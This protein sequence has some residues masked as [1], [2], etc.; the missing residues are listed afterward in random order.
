[1][2]PFSASG[3]ALLRGRRQ[4]SRFKEVCPVLLSP[5]PTA[6]LPLLVITA[7]IW[8]KTVRSAISELTAV[9]STKELPAMVR[10]SIP[11]PKASPTVPP[12]EVRLLWLSSS[13]ME[14]KAASTNRLLW[15][16]STPS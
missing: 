2:L 3:K 1:M 11:Q 10:L 9:S 14:L 7:S 12:Q 4:S 6:S 13:T 16:V 8:V 15:T 5:G